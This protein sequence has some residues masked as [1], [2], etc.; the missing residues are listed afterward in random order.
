MFKCLAGVALAVLVV[1]TAGMPASAS[2]TEKIED[3]V[4]HALEEFESILEDFSKR[5]G[6]SKTSDKQAQRELTDSIEDVEDEADDEIEKIEKII[7]DADDRRTMAAGEN[8]IREIRRAEAATI[9]QLEG[10]YDDWQRSKSSPTTTAPPPPTTTSTAPPPPTTTAPPPTTRTTTAPPTTTTTP[11]RSTTDPAPS[12][13]SNTS[14]D[15]RA[16]IIAGSD[17]GT[18]FVELSRPLP[19]PSI[20]TTSALEMFSV[21]VPPA[22]AAF[23]SGPFLL[24]EVLIAAV[25]STSPTLAAS[26]LVGSIA[27]AFLMIRDRDEEPS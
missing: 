23:L 8:A 15:D 3:H 22:L 13:D 9:E 4:G 6:D 14:D 19:G 26:A 16:A 17:S 21:A 11:D 18:P 10:M 1:V 24:G 7:D 25:T 20:P 5:L 27:V 12:A 2:D